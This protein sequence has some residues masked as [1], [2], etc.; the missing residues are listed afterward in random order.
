MIYEGPSYENYK[1]TIWKNA[2]LIIV[3]AG[4]KCGLHWFLMD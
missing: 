4:F 3:I 1:Y 2:E